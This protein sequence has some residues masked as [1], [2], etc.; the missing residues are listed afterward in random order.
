M[1]TIVQVRIAL[2]SHYIALVCTVY[3]GYSAVSKDKAP[4][5]KRLIKREKVIAS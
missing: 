5:G 3:V 1:S 2:R 4:E